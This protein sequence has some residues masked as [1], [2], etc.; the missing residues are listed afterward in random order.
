MPNIVALYQ[1]I[2]R[3]FFDLEDGEKFLAND[4][5]REHTSNL[6]TGY[7]KL[8]LQK[9]DSVEIYPDTACSDW[10]PSEG[11]KNL[12]IQNRLPRYVHE[13]I[14][15]DFENAIHLASSGDSRKKMRR[16][17]KMAR[18]VDHAMLLK[19]HEALG[20]L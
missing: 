18:M 1:P 20:R 7:G 14:R 19:A 9:R 12:E 5:V 17:A 13:R 2:F 11:W 3:S 10:I 6:E 15:R 8:F 16:N 4:W